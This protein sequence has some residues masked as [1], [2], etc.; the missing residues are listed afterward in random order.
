MLFIY[1]I[2]AGGEG[3]AGSGKEMCLSSPPGDNAPGVWRTGAPFHVAV[4]H[5]TLVCQSYAQT[6]IKFALSFSVASHSQ[7]FPSPLNALL[8]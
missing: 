6:P 8:L 7:L 3:R 2:C 1:I 4:H 5:L